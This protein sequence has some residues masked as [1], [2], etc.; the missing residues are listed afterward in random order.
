MKLP[1]LLRK[2]PWMAI[3]LLGSLFAASVAEPLRAAEPA[4]EF[5][6]ELR[7]RGYF[8]LALI[9][10]D[11]M[12]KN[13]LAPQDFRQTIGFER[14]VTLI[15]A[16]QTE[17]D[18]VARE[19]QLDQAQNA[20][21]EF[22]NANL[23]HDKAPDAQT[24]L[25]NLLVERARMKVE[26]VR[27][28]PATAETS[29]AEARTLYDESHQLFVDQI[30]GIRTQLTNIP[31]N[32]NP[33]NAADANRIAKRDLLR[34][35]YLNAQLLSAVILEE[36]AESAV[37]GS[38]EYKTLLKGAA[39]EFQNIYEKYR[40]R[41]AGLYAR[42]YQ[43]RCYQKI[44]D[45]VKA[46]S[47]LEDLLEQPDTPD[48]FRTL[49]LKTLNMAM[50]SWNDESQAKYLAATIHGDK[51]VDTIRPDEA[52]QQEWL[53]LQFN[54]A[55]AHKALADKQRAEKNTKDAI[56]NDK[57]A[58]R[59]M[60]AVSK[61]S[62]PLQ[63]P[64][65]QQVN[66]WGGNGGTIEEKELET[67]EEA[68]D[69]GKDVLLAWQAAAQL[70][71]QL[72]ARIAR[73]KDPAEKAV[74]EKQ[75]ADAQKLSTE[76]QQKAIDYFHQ[77]LLFAT[78][79]TPSRELN[80]VHYYLSFLNYSTGK[81]LEAGILGEFVARRYPSSDVA[82]HCG[83]FALA[84][85]VQLHS[86]ANPDNRVFEKRVIV[87]CARFLAQQWPTEDE[88]IIAAATLVPFLLQPPVAN[89]AVPKESV[90]EA[91]EVV[92]NM[93]ADSPKRA[94]VEIKVGQVQWYAFLRGYADLSNTP[95]AEKDARSAELTR[96]REQA[97]TLLAAGLEGSKETAEVDVKLALATL[98]LGQIYVFDKEFEQAVTLFEDP[99]I[100]PLKLLADKDPATDLPGYSIGVYDAALKAYMGTLATAK[101]PLAQIEKVKTT[102]NSL[103][104]SLA[105][106][107]NGSAKLL[108]IYVSLATGLKKQMA[109][110]SPSKR[111][112]LAKAFR[113]FLQQVEANSNDF[114]KLYW[115]AETFLNMGDGLRDKAE[116]VSP[117]AKDYYEQAANAYNKIL[118]QAAADK[119]YY[120]EDLRERGIESQIIL[121]RAS[122][123][124][125]RGEFA[126]AIEIFTDL[127]AKENGRLDV[128]IEAARTLQDWAAADDP[129][130]FYTALAGDNWDQKQNRYT[131]WGWSGIVSRTAQSPKHQKEFFDAQLNVARCY[132][133]FAATQEGDDKAKNLDSARKAIV[134][135]MLS[136]PELGGRQDE[137]NALFEEI[138]QARGE[139]APLGLEAERERITKT[140]TTPDASAGG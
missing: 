55:L 45:H 85:Y 22:L 52:P 94:A 69:A 99:R 26:Q 106:D 48:A 66:E 51:L 76:G 112:E 98:S 38:E 73:E 122:T 72:P 12:E 42:L 114:S 1:P 47:Y 23:T 134:T 136:Y 120:P 65:I 57:V 88:G 25:G 108:N 64:A 53:E 10:I 16:A 36:T 63:K 119:S 139:K 115:V 138:Q 78:P 7:D 34:A 39:D 79:E 83:R 125:A 123:T 135:T 140:P 37:E 3:C 54:L 62:G 40:T 18:L 27:R 110:A 68:K 6:K 107:E 124:R 35:A 127:L 14:G 137:Y 130:K 50:I 24:Q 31:P 70:V 95:E 80:I 67:F 58:M 97:K 59:L 93:P 103:N 133:R 61:Q 11:K 2:R 126:E 111:S 109:Q 117:E 56:T 89:G 100:G 30:E 13:N 43:A 21:R 71:T 29:R 128:Q 33:K 5:L 86:K 84:S 87:D 19:R 8:E 15:R 81:Y 129:T 4:A 60:V 113:S 116:T 92:N 41:T 132:Y 118:K 131:V 96:I 74:L 44:G 121:R 75:L 105:S 101:D 20:I 82:R 17:R 77:A 49:R 91:I 32:L 90:D 28:N 9:Y 46:L 104:A 102:M